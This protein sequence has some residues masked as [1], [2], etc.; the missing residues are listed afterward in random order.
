MKFT[1]MQDFAKIAIFKLLPF[2]LD[3][4]KAAILQVL[5]MLALS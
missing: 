5:V 3:L 1:R 4:N 2:S